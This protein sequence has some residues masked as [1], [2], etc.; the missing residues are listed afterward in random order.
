[1]KDTRRLSASS[2]RS[3]L[4]GV[5]R[6]LQE[7]GEKALITFIT[8]GDPDMG[9]TKRIIFELERS[10]ADIIELGMPFSDP[11]ADGP[12]IQASSERA[13]KG[14]ATVKDVLRLVREI[15]G[16][17][18]IPVVLFGYYNPV[19]VYGLERFARDAA[20]AG[21]D[22]VLVV[23]LPPEE[24]GGLKRELQRKALDLIYL[25]TP[26]SNTGRMR[27]VASKASGF[28]YYVSVA[29]VTGARKTLADRIPAEI[30][31]I[32]KFT[33]LPVCV[34]FGISTPAQARRAAACADGVV[35]G[36]AIIDIIARNI[37]AKDL[38]A[39]MGRFVSGLK[40]GMG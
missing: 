32:R 36:S 31:K 14:G 4:E 30:R 8:A 34:G 9:T 29:G 26:T 38:A 13:L 28:I 18:S 12:T 11:M 40:K 23:D 15:R 35:V 1:M 22:G 25:V 27:L 33:G 24:A 10:G 19:F 39:R 17:S 21:A 6:G 5:F 20:D 7:R 2:S 37:G 16:K 3:R